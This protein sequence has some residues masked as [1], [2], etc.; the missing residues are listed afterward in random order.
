MQCCDKREIE[1]SALTNLQHKENVQFQLIC[2]LEETYLVDIY[3]DD[4]VA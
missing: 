4:L 1:N 2:G 3:S